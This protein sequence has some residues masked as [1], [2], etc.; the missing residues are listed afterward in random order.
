MDLAT[1]TTEYYRNNSV[2][3]FL[4]EQFCIQ[5]KYPKKYSELIA[6]AIHADYCEKHQVPYFIPEDD[7]LRVEE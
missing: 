1:E 3:L 4:T 7:E 6:R 2:S 5:G